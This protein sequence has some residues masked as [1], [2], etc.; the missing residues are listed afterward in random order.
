[1][2]STSPLAPRR[3]RN[4]LI[5][6]GIVV[7]YAIA[8]FFVL[9][10]I[11]RS[12]AVKQL[13]VALKRPVTIEK[14]AINP[15][16]LSITV[17]GLSVA[18]HDGSELAGFDEFYA[19]FQLSSAFRRMWF[20]REIRLERP[21]GQIVVGRDGALNIA[22]LVPESAAQ[23]EPPPPPA[24]LPHFLI[25]TLAVSDGS[26]RFRDLS[27]P[28]VFENFAG[29]VTVSLRRFGAGNDTAGG[30]SLQ[31]TTESGE[32]FSF[33]GQV[34]LDN[35]T[36]S[37]RWTATGVNVPKYDPLHHQMTLFEVTEGKLS[38]DVQFVVDMHDGLA[39]RIDPSD[40]AIEDLH[41]RSRGEDQDAIYI[42]A[43]QIAGIR[44][45][46]ANHT[47][48]IE[49]LAIEPYSAENAPAWA[50]RA[51]NP[52]ATAP[53][54]ALFKVTRLADGSIDL[55]SLLTLRLGAS[56][57]QDGT[58][59]PA[60]SWSVSLGEAAIVDS[61]IDFTDLTNERPAHLLL[62]QLTATAHNVSTDR[63]AEIPFEAKVRWQEKGSVSLKGGLRQE[64]LQAD[65]D[66]DA[67]DLTLAGLG[68]YLDP[69]MNV[70]VGDG[71]VRASGKVTLSRESPD[72]EP[73]LSFVG[74]GG[75]DNLAVSTATG[76]K[77]FASLGS[78]DLRGVSFHSPPVRLDIAEIAVRSP[79][80]TAAV[81]N[82]GSINLASMMKHPETPAAA[83]AP[84]AAPASAPVADDSRPMITIGR[85]I[86]DD[87]RADLADRSLP[88]EFVSSMRDFGGT[89]SGLSSEELARADVDLKGTLDGK[90]PFHVSGTIN[91]LSENAF[92][93]LKVEFSGIGLA[94]FT[95]Y[96]G[97]YLGYKIDRGRL[98][99][100]LSY[101]LSSRVLEAENA[102]V[103]DNFYLG[104]TVESPD[105]MKLPL[106]LALA[107]LR[108][109]SGKIDIDL[110]IRGNL[111]D[112]DFRYGSLVWKAIGNL[113]M[114]AATAPF[115]LLGRLIP[116]GGDP[117]ALSYVAFA[118]GSAE[119]DAASVE[120]IATLANA[121]Y[122]RPALTL[123]IAAAPAPEIDT[124]VLR[125]E[126]FTA[127][128]VARKVSDLAAAGTPAADPSV[129]TIDAGE[130]TALIREEF[131]V[132]FPDELA[133]PAGTETAD[134]SGT[135]KPEKPGVIVR[136]FRKIFGSSGG[137]AAKVP[138]AAQAEVAAA[139]GPTPEEMEAR[140]LGRIEIA[141]D[142]LQALAT[143]R[144][145]AVRDQLLATGKVE[146]ERLFLATASTGEGEKPATPEPR[147]NFTL[148]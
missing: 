66:V 38:F 41:I 130:R 91:P 85:V 123:E 111:D 61:T 89:I 135:G 139:P 121:L 99:L 26:L 12:Q 14:V 64:P 108:D 104:D 126:R 86:I 11:I 60:S 37:G 133:P 144:A 34:N 29:P 62:D 124:P 77:P 59:A 9:P 84:A 103:F 6:A 128:L 42:P 141:P 92:T 13:S 73:A 132:A 54:V 115:S 5:L 94:E 80:I 58:T 32:R 78:L 127:Q 101:H 70:R 148:K 45:D 145:T 47:A 90:A 27:K 39:W 7:L 107:L 100:D 82:D 114:K 56:N 68:P 120:K 116:G 25:D 105:A 76:D 49:R 97:R 57:S 50:W 134:A 52:E 110:P 138:P 98:S 53:G 118:P 106:K 48:S 28:A 35:L 140:L 15:F 43:V 4:L 55:A 36:L 147:V 136:T 40:I 18:D 1:M 24:P 117:E 3:R 22:D 83:G 119:L 112:P 2:N 71:T 30:I 88:T 113:I 21:R 65:V 63:A 122:D 44:A 17:R 51:P 93:D 142:Q 129:V 75:M 143:A 87:G 23:S 19:N 8:G 69:W 10:P 33:E 81:E 79:A 146:A 125:A 95:P 67:A 20:F 72:A 74:T 137:P 96:S 131:A 46:S 102:L 109:R 31:G 16:V